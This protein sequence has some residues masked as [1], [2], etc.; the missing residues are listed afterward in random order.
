MWS[1]LPARL[2]WMLV[3]L[4]SE[5]LSAS[6]Q[7]TLVFFCLGSS[8]CC[9]IGWPKFLE[10]GTGGRARYGRGR[11]EKKESALGTG[12][13]GRPIRF[14]FGLIYGQKKEADPKASP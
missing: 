2:G 14:L 5:D 9:R 11:E 8:G 13:R 1:D 12:A 10:G 4:V 6:V 3:N 7:P